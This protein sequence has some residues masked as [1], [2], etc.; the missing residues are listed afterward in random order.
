MLTEG[1]EYCNF[2]QLETRLLLILTLLTKNFL[3]VL[4]SS[5][6]NSNL[7]SSSEDSR[8]ASNI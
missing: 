7:H 2:S 1:V 3:S 4:E 5:D 8:S 6:V